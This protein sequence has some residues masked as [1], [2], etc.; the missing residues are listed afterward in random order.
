MGVCVMPMCMA[1]PSSSSHSRHRDGRNQSGKMSGKKNIFA[2]YF[3]FNFQQPCGRR[4]GRCVG[5]VPL[6]NRRCLFTV[7]QQHTRTNTHSLTHSL[8]T[9]LGCTA[10]QPTTYPHSCIHTLPHTHTSHS[11]SL[12]VLRNRGINSTIHDLEANLRVSERLHS[13][14]Y[15]H[16]DANKVEPSAI[17]LLSYP[18][19]LSLLPNHMGTKRLLHHTVQP[20]RLWPHVVSLL[21]C[22]DSTPLARR[23]LQACRPTAEQKRSASP[24]NSNLNLGMARSVGCTH[25][26]TFAPHS[27]R[28]PHPTAY[29]NNPTYRIRTAC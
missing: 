29:N 2:C 27:T 26:C 16:R 3:F 15:T 18:H 22:C 20:A 9:L 12:S 28:H 19:L 8:T 14:G 7:S 6:R 21:L 4:C 1:A 25:T 23:P 11:L 13:N 5:T 10:S 24:V 17:T